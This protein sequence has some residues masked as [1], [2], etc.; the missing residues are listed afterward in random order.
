[1]IKFG[2]AGNSDSFFEQGHKST[3]EAPGWLSQQGLDSFEYSFGR[4]VLL[5]DETALKIRGEAEKNNIEISV[6]APYYINFASP[7]PEK[8][9]N[10]IG[11][12]IK[13]IKKLK[14]LGGERCVFHPGSCGKMKREMALEKLYSGI[15]LLVDALNQNDIKDVLICP[16][17]MGKQN[18][19]GTVSEIIKI[20]NMDERFVPCCDFGH[21]NSRELGSLKTSD[22][23]RRVIEEVFNGVG[24]ARARKMHIHFSKIMFGNKGEIKHLTF[25]DEKYGPCFENLIP[26]IKEFNMEPYIICESSGTQAEDS[27]YM[28]KMFEKSK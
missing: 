22:D 25:E 2:V 17:T 18:Q 4:G 7:E 20:C 3:F 14:V 1:M 12:I 5:S 6:H 23:F 13:S 16:E 8:I 11:Y 24:E 15:E 19:L 28:K 9:D 27:I 21:I 26:V 10:S